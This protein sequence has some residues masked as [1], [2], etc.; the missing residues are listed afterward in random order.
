MNIDTYLYSCISIYF[1]SKILS[2]TPLCHPERSAAQSRDLA[3]RL[4]EVAEWPS[5]LGRVVRRI[6]S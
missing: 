1:G 6:I 2:M 5:L 4:S 3:F